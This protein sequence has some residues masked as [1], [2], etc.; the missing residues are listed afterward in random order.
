MDSVALKIS[1]C[2]VFNIGHVDYIQ[3]Q[4]FQGCL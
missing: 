2:C 4:E 1:N 3:G